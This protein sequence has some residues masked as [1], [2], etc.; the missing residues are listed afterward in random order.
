MH[1]FHG[2]GDPV[3]H[4]TKYESKAIAAVKRSGR[5]GYQ[6]Y[7]YAISLQLEYFT[8]QRKLKSNKIAQ[9]IALIGANV[10]RQD[11]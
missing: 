11:F 4:R 7:L 9:P 5:L 10:L 2:G 8:F 6:F 3:L 1:L